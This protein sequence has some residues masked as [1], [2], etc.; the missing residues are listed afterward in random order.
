MTYL[1]I[2]FFYVI[3]ESRLTA[4]FNNG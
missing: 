1:F 3:T 4:G 2:K